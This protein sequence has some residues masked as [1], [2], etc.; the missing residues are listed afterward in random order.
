MHIL[1]FDH[2]FLQRNRLDIIFVCT[3][4]QCEVVRENHVLLFWAKR[5]WRF[6]L[7][8]HVFTA[9]LTTLPTCITNT[10][11]K[12]YQTDLQL[13]KKYSI[14]PFRRPISTVCVLW[15]ALNNNS[16][17]NTHAPMTQN[18]SIS[19]PFFFPCTLPWSVIKIMTLLNLFLET[20]PDKLWR[21]VG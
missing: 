9:W 15:E 4:D 13:K 1:Y 14:S 6:V 21:A 20:D 5:N 12:H 3:C 7:S 2:T 10:H 11:K 17:L 18:T 8:Q 19:F 16:S